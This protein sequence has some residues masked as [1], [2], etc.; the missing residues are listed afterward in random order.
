[1]SF[2]EPSTYAKALKRRYPNLVRLVRRIERQDAGLP[3]LWIERDENDT[4]KDAD[5]GEGTT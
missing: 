3:L 5:G 1:M 2:L 4:P